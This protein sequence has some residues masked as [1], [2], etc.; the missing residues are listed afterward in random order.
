M[1]TVRP[2]SC[3]LQTITVVEGLASIY[4]V[5]RSIVC[6]LKWGELLGDKIW[7]C[8]PKGFFLK[9]IQMLCSISIKYDHVR[10]L[11]LKIRHLIIA[12]DSKNENTYV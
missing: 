2:S 7:L 1:M 8:P 12:T 11:N 5:S 9:N 6:H 3:P 10:Y 4:P